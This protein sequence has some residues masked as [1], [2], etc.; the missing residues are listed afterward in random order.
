MG[1]L[2]VVLATAGFMADV[3]GI[4]ARSGFGGTQIVVLGTGVAFITIASAVPRWVSASAA[5]SILMVFVSVCGTLVL[6]ELWIEMTAPVRKN[7]GLG[8][9]GMF[10]PDPKIGYRLA[11]NWSGI[12]DD[13]IVIAEYATNSIGHRDEEPKVR[14]FQR[15]ILLIGDSFAFGYGLDQME[16]IDKSVEGISDGRIDAYNAGI[17]GYGPPAIL[18]SLVRCDWFS[19]TD[20][21][22]LFFNNDLRDDNLRLD[23]GLTVFA[24]HL[25]PRSKADGSPFSD[26]E[27]GARDRQS[28]RPA[29]PGPG[30]RRPDV[31]ASGDA[32]GAS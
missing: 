23:M 16:T 13:G 31:L 12:F 32:S 27:Y 5:A 24:G 4:G 7:S 21:V 8:L 11:P 19:G 2:G 17:Q 14:D 10:V 25:V 3:I 22:Y 1:G 28:T 30:S 15:S 18:E 26:A 20:V 9:R 29:P 6:G